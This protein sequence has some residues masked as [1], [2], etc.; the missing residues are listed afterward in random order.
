[1]RLRF[2]LVLFSIF[3]STHCY[4]TTSPLRI[5]V[6]S[7]FS[8]I[9]E[10]LIAQ[11][12][13]RTHIPVQIISGSSGTLFLQI[14]HGAPFDVFL[15][16][17]STRPQKL[18]EASL[19]VENSLQTYAYGQLALW[20]NN[21]VVTLEALASLINKQ[22]FAIANPQT[23]PYGKAAKET[24]KSLN[25]WTQVQ[26]SLVTGM[27]INQTFQQIRS[28]AVNIGIVANSQLVLNQLTGT[29]IPSQYHQPIKQQLVILKVSK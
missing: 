5:A 27:N 1:M 29:I 2:V 3:V 11:F 25:L 22:R 23:A 14:S 16:A 21:E 15:S 26:G 13:E 8:P 6:A 4:S 20:S 28:Q 24:L 17:D 10:Q 7:N 12:T 19:T 9:L 18:K